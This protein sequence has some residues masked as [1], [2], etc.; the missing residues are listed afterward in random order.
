MLVTLDLVYPLIQ[1][2]WE[3]GE[4]GGIRKAM[5]G[6]CRFQFVTLSLSSEL[7]DLVSLSL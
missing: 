7:A 4:L 2:Y 3:I 5:E 1:R 6:P